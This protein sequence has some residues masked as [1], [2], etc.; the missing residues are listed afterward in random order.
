VSWAS[1]TLQSVRVLCKLARPHCGWPGM[2]ST[3]ELGRMLELKVKLAQHSRASGS[4]GCRPTTPGISP[5]AARRASA[6]SCSSGGSVASLATE[7]RVQVRARRL[8]AADRLT[9]RWTD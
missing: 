4:G 7:N 3:A 8:A 9:A 5:F 6:T 2:Q 1:Q